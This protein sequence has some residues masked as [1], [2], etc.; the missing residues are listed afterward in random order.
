MSLRQ[1]KVLT[2]DVVGT[3]IDFEGGMIAYI[4]KTSGLAPE[5]LADDCILESYRRVRAGS[6]R[7]RYPDTLVPVYR[8]MADELGLPTTA[9]LA[10]GFRDSIEGWPAFPD[11]VAAL[12]RLKATP[13]QVGLGK[14]E[15]VQNVQ[16]A[17]RVPPDAN[18]EVA[19]R[20]LVLVDDVLTSGATAE[21]CARALLRAG[22]QSVD[23]LVFARV[24]AGTRPPI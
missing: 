10:E 12:K 20:R 17:F 14:S 7:M 3:L 15:R 21:A 1:F 11:S 13:Q 24:V 6:D 22:A 16:G 5:R 23:V 9:G 18:I 2:F 4:R 19:G 8:A